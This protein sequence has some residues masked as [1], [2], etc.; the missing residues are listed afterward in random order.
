M[1]KDLVKGQKMLGVI[2]DYASM[3]EA[4]VMS[5][6]NIVRGTIKSWYA[7]VTLD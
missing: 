2:G 3:L 5:V 7:P 1:R 4:L 6:H